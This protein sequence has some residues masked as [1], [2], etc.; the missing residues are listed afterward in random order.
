VLKNA[1]LTL[2]AVAFSIVVLE[3]AARWMGLGHPLIYES[4]LAY[5]YRLK[6]D[7]SAV[8]LRG[9]QVSVNH[10]GL[11][12][13]AEWNPDAR[14]RVLF[15]GDSITFGGT[16][17]SDKE[18]FSHLACQQI[19]EASC[20]NAGTNAYGVDNMARR[21][22]VEA[23]RL[24]PTDLVVTL[25]Y[26]DT[27]RGMVQIESQA[28]FTKP[29][30]GPLLGLM[31]IFA[32]GLDV[33]RAAIRFEP[34]YARYMPLNEETSAEATRAMEGLFAAL[35]TV[36]EQGINVLMV[37]SETRE[38]ILHGRSGVGALVFDLMQRS[39]LPMLDTKPVMNADAFY[40][41]VHLEVEGHKLYA[42]AIA[43]R[44]TMPQPTQ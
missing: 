36:R 8:R 41:A 5:G 38:Q 11:R 17:I 18:T 32:Y 34:D 7:Q 4:N 33:T 37:Y 23:G 44:L 12:S 2:L 21:L 24:K 13:T 19:P 31:E 25:Y 10:E 20:G 16:Y 14:R 39:G 26:G 6:P 3:V 29:P 30:P 9:A 22:A 35:T 40:D 42:K 15:V 1:L 28:V 43:E 27:L